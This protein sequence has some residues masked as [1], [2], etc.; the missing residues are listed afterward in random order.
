MV[1]WWRWLGPVLKARVRLETL[2]PVHVG[3]GGNRITG[4]DYV[5]FNGH[6]YV[7]DFDRLFELLRGRGLLQRY[8]EFMRRGGGRKLLSD[9]LRGAGLLSRQILD[10][11]SLYKLRCSEGLQLDGREVKTLIRGVGGGIYLPGSSLKGSLRTAIILDRLLAD[12]ALRDRIVRLVMGSRGRRGGK[13]YGAVVEDVLRGGG[14]PDRDLLRLLKPSDLFPIS[15]VAGEAARLFSL[16]FTNGRPRLLGYLEVIPPR[17]LF[18]GLIEFSDDAGV[19]RYIGDRISLQD[20]LR[21]VRVRSGKLLDRLINR[22]AG[23]PQGAEAAG[24]KDKLVEIRDR[25]AGGD[26]VSTLGFG[27]GYWGVTVTEFKPDL[28]PSLPIRGARNLRGQD[29]P[30]S[31]RVVDRG[32]GLEPLGWVSLRLEEVGR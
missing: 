12:E 29:F 32:S 10:S 4:L 24:V 23:V 14:D 13:K 11:A 1:L 20:V 16:S 9:F 17:T 6:L 8:M 18:E 19:V 15:D 26:A 30:R 21:A 28:L 22:L 2:T 25:L 31:M 5:L 27:Q 3:V 7:M